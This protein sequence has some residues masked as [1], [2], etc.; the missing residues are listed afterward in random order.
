MAEGGGTGERENVPDRPQ[1]PKRGAGAGAAVVDR[2][3]RIEGLLAADLDKLGGAV[4]SATVARLDAR[5]TAMVELVERLTVRMEELLGP[6]AP[7][8]ARQH[9]DADID[10]RPFT[11]AGA[12]GGWHQ[13]GPVDDITR[14]LEALCVRLENLAGSRQA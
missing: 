13:L 11:T 5:L 12:S 3:A 14:R 7:P 9:A 6:S 1:L 2:L 4:L 10:I 8:E